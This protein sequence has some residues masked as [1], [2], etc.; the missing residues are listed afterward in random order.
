M[1]LMTS[2]PV[3]RVITGYYDST[4]DHR[5]ILGGISGLDGFCL[6]TGFS[7]HGFMLAPAIGEMLANFIAGSTSDPMLDEFSLRRFNASN[8]SEGLQI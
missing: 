1:P 3:R 8:V 7:G 4:P 5:P 2:L 6:A